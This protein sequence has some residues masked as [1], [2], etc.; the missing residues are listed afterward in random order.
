MESVLELS[1]PIGLPL[2]IAAGLLAVLFG[3]NE[4]PLKYNL[5]NLTVRWR[6]TLLTALAFTSVVALLTVMLAFVNGMYRLTESS[7][8]PENVIILSDG[9]TD[10][11]FSNLSSFDVGDVEN[12]QG[13][14]RSRGRPLASR[15]TYLVVNQVIPHARSGQP[16][17]RFL[18]VRG[19]DDP[20]MAAAVHRVR[21][22]PGG[23]LFSRAG[24]QPLQHSPALAIQAVLGEGIAREL[25]RDRTPD[26]LAQARNPHRL[27]VGDVFLLADRPWVVVGVMQSAGSA[28]DSEVW[29]KRSI[30][31]PL[32]GKDTYTSVVVRCEDAARAKGL[33]E[34]IAT[35]Y[36]KAALQAHIE[37]DYYAGLSETNK[38]LLWAIGFVTVV[39]SVGGVFG[40]MNTMFAA[41]SQ[42]TQDIGVLRLLG[43][44]RRQILI[45][46]LLESLVIAMVGGVSGCALGSLAD[47][48]TANSI[49]T[50]SQGGGKFVVL[51][52]VVDANIIAV[53]LLV[54]VVMG[55][56]GGLL[57]ALSAMRLR[58]LEALR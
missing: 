33:K 24:L 12:Q 34:F 9:M 29:A 2:A 26:Q 21:L 43:Y 17:R 14:A 40:V 52:L 50:G 15:E 38:Q 28:F 36:K 35:R 25:G 37:T 6:T 5:R 10:E 22:H 3:V 1:M 7:G 48:W 27:D 47:G 54:T 44:R 57:P 23:V 46:F 16:K 11:S 39:M 45:S 20:A 53:G 55:A 31:A 18:Q 8:Y 41:I 49:V 30:V 51:Q 13:V 19:I 42:R 4:V 32:L 56:V 58:P